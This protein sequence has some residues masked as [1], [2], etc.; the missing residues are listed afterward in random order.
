MSEAVCIWFGGGLGGG[1]DVGSG[2]GGGEL[3]GGGEGGGLGGEGLG[4]EGLGGGELGGVELGGGGEG[5]GEEH[6]RELGGGLGGVGLGGGHFATASHS[7]QPTTSAAEAGVDG[8]CRLGCVSGG[9]VEGGDGSCDKSC[10]GGGEIGGE[11]EE[12]G[13]WLRGRELAGTPL[14]AA[15]LRYSTSLRRAMTPRDKRLVS[16]PERA[17]SAK[18]TVLLGAQLPSGA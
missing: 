9:C 2:L 13:G 3:E 5:C 10:G 7:T 15:A 14:S 4:G 8:S 11:R 17:S 12:G 1:A 18:A 16:V 6:G